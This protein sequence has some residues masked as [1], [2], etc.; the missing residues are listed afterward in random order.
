MAR[1]LTGLEHLSI[2]MYPTSLLQLD[3]I[4]RADYQPWFSENQLRDLAGNSFT[5][6]IIAAVLI[7]VMVNWPKQ[8]Q[9]D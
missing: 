6:G 2:Q 1:P 3:G 9:D 4:E 7:S 8:A 5:G